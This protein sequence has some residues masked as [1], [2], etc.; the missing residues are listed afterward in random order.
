M[1]PMA[2]KQ[3]AFVQEYLL[4]LDASKAVVRA[5]YHATGQRAA[6]I[7][8]Q[9]LQKPP[10]QEAI[11]E[12]LAARAKRTEISQDRTLKEIAR[13]AFLDPLELFANDGTLLPLNKMPED[14]RRAIASLEVEELWEGTGKDRIAIGRLKKIKLVSKEGTLTLVGRHLG[15]FNEKDNAPD[16]PMPVVVNVNVVDARKPA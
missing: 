12:A 7:G 9:L 14:A 2:A 10:V 4:D 5:G 3:V 1:R 6:E 16:M 11:R 15:I 8:Y 13:V